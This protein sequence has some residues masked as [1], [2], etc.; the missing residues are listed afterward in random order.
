MRQGLINRRLVMGS[1]WY[2]L[3]DKHKVTGNSTVNIENG[4][5]KCE[6]WAVGESAYTYLTFTN[7]LESYAEVLFEAKMVG[8]T[9]D[10]TRAGG[11]G[12]NQW[13]TAQDF[14]GIGG[15]LIDWM[16][17]DSDKW[18]T[19][20]VVIPGSIDKPFT[21]VMFGA[22]NNSIGEWWFRRF[23]I[24]FY[25]HTNLALDG[26][27]ARL[28]KDSTGA[29]WRIDRDPN[30]QACL[31]VYKVEAI[32]NY[33]RVYYD[34]IAGWGNPII[35][36]TMNVAGGRYGWQCQPGTITRNYCDLY[37][38]DQNGTGQNPATMGQASVQFSAL[39]G[40]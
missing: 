13:S 27:I 38:Y 29:A 11:L 26:R 10:P 7:P 40:L 14:S 4:I 9:S 37:F 16:P 6:S 23:E 19:Y 33:L 1:G 35:N 24:N 8:G 28:V 30:G 36:T 17:I 18:K 39:S 34:P 22:F 15:N 5:L 12:Y 3:P 21:A 20:R 2:Y 31:G 32:S 25:N